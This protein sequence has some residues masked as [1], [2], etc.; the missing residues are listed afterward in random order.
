MRTIGLVSCV[1]VLMGCAETVPMQYTRPPVPVADASVPVMGD[2]AGPVWENDAGPD[3]EPYDPEPDA[4]VPVTDAG[5]PLPDAYVPP[6]EPDAGPSIVDTDAGP[7]VPVYS[8]RHRCGYNGSTLG[9]FYVNDDGSEVFLCAA[10]CGV[11]MRV[12]CEPDSSPSGWYA[13]VGCSGRFIHGAGE[14][15]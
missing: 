10:R 4:Y 1:L 11:T 7:P 9:W 14:C 2:D 5:I 15:Q 12:M 3:V 6:V 13:A 8:D